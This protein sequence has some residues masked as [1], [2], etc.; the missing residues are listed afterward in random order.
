MVSG[1]LFGSG[2]FVLFTVLLCIVDVFFSYWFS[3]LKGF[4]QLLDFVGVQKC[5][6]LKSL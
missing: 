4:F 5:E 1:R 6:V 3:I 2:S